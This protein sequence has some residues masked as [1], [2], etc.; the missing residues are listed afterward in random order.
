MD[1]N[2]KA[3]LIEKI[4]A[5]QEDLK[6]PREVKA[7]L[8]ERAR[9]TRKTCA[10]NAQKTLYLEVRRR[11]IDRRRWTRIHEDLAQ[12]GF[13][14]FVHNL[15]RTQREEA[16]SVQVTAARAQ[17]LALFPGFENL[18]TRIRSGSNFVK[19]AETSVSQFLAYE[20]AYQM[21]AARNHQTAEELHRLAGKVRHMWQTDPDMPLAMALVHSEAQP[22]KLSV[23][24]IPTR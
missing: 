9:L 24:G 18:P 19:L 10:P 20:H 21:R 5:A 1:A 22:A 3:A 6:D 23:V 15:E 11:L 16:T 4:K 13:A 17:Q 14:V 2:L 7:V 8:E 12:Q